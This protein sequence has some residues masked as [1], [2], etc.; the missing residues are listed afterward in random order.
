MMEALEI[1]SVAAPISAAVAIGACMCYCV[2]A[3]RIRALTSRIQQL[4]TTQMHPMHQVHPIPAHSY[5]RMP[6]VYTEN[7]SAPSGMIW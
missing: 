1:V 5:I 3:G 7:P 6:P 4:E 2:I